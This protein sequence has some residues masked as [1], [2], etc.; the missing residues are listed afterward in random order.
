MRARQQSICRSRIFLSF[1]KSTPEARRKKPYDSDERCR[2]EIHSALD[3]AS[4][5]SVEGRSQG[6]F[7]SGPWMANPNAVPTNQYPR[8]A[9]ATRKATSNDRLHRHFPFPLR[10]HDCEITVTARA[11]VSKILCHQL[12]IRV[13]HSSTAIR[14]RSSPNHPASSFIL[15]VKFWS[16]KRASS[17]MEP[18]RPVTKMLPQT[19]QSGLNGWTNSAVPSMK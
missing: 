16:R 8:Q 5:T 2:K 14:A 10:E 4:L 13:K 11:I 12:S 3:G 19:C 17:T 18:W 15:T 7:G 1:L 9:I 6:F